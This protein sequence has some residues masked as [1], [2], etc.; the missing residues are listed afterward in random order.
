MVAARPFRGAH[1][2]PLFGRRDL[3][4]EIGRRLDHAYDGSGQGLVL[5]GPG[6]IGKSRLLAAVME[7][8]EARGFDVLYG[9]ALPEE[10]P[11]PF[12]L[13]RDLVSSRAADAPL[14]GDGEA[15]LPMFL[16]PIGESPGRVPAGEWTPSGPPKPVDELEEILAPVGM[17]AIE[18][19]DAVR[20]EMLGRLVDTFLEW[21]RRRPLVLAID[22]L[23]FADASSLA[24]LTHLARDLPAAP[25]AIVATASSGAEAPGRSRPAVDALL[26][27]SSFH[28]F[29]LQPL[30]A[31]EVAE[32]ATWILGGHAPAPEEVHRWHAQ[33]EGN[34]LFVEQLVRTATGSAAPEEEPGGDIT[35]VLEA[36][37]AALGDAD[38]RILTYATV[39][40]K[41]FDFASLA[42]VATLDEER[43]TE[44][45]DHLVRAGLLRERGNEVYEFVSEGLRASVYADLTETRRRILHRKAGRTL[46]AK[47][48]SDVELARQFYLGQDEPRAVEYNIRA[49]QAATRAFAYDAAVSHIERAVGAERRRSDRDARREVRL[50]TEE[51]RLLDD[52]GLWTRSDEVLEEAVQLARAHSGA[53]LEL[54]RALL[55]LA[56]TRADRSDYASAEALATEASHGLGRWGTPRDI[57]AANRVLGIVFWRLGDLPRAEQCQ[58]AAL[59]IAERE[60]TLLEQGHSLVD[61][62]NTMVPRGERY[63]ATALE[64]YRKAADLF[65]RVDEPTAR[66]RVLMNRGVLEYTVGLVD[67]AFRDVEEA[68]VTAE[69]ARS[70]IYTAYCLLNLAQW[71]AELGR[72]GPAQTALDRVQSAVAPLGDALAEQQSAMTRGM[73]AEAQG[74]L[75][76]AET[77]YQDGLAR[78]RELRLVAETSEMLFRLARLSMLKGELVESRARLDDALASGLREHRPDFAGRLRDLES[79]LARDAAPPAPADRATGGTPS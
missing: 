62:A 75:D 27:S 4:D 61:V 15:T 71:H 39:L 31:T 59:E 21:A 69:R 17:T 8:A 65:A 56:Q 37:A 48:A 24:F 10:L 58:R 13:V 52:L 54:G 57:M 29:P 72:P 49:A 41:E 66:A 50:L 43:V 34:P 77:H 68:L 3:L 12:S 2:P 26:D 79:S 25:L 63:L 76:L 19:L 53:E 33:T 55:A 11:A 28:P 9:R 36:R 7:A 32:F 22:D 67:E 40:G 73:I 38:R 18:G 35:Q 46:E 1:A 14:V 42:V 16:A 70:P 44:S 74:A 30:S 45:L 6:G 64:L 78:A 51:G 23:P 60:G 20:D 5:L 47:G